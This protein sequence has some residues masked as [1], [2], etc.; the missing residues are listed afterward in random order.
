MHCTNKILV[1]L[2]HIIIKFPSCREK[3]DLHYGTW[4]PSTI[5]FLYESEVL[6]VWFIHTLEFR[7][8]ADLNASM[9]V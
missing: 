5:F 3:Y 1:M 4:D 8:D 7:Q 9:S 2:Y 6:S